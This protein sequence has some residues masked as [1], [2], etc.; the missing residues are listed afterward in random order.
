MLGRLDAELFRS[1]YSF[2]PSATVADVINQGF[3]RLSDALPE[4]D[5]PVLQV[6]DEIV[7]EC[8]EGHVGEVARLMRQECEVPIY[9]PE[10]PVPLTIPAEISS[11][12]NWFDQE[13]IS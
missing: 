2:I 10:T 9:I 5:F 11:G 3:Y 13:K 12:Q 8:N 7:V 4:G 6:H 1:A